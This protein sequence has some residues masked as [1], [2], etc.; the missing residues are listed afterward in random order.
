MMPFNQVVHQSK[1]NLTQ[2]LTEGSS[3]VSSASGYFDITFSR[4]T[5]PRWS[6]FR[7]LMRASPVA[8]TKRIML[9]RGT[10]MSRLY[11]W[12]M[13]TRWGEREREESMQDLGSVHLIKKMNRPHRARKGKQPVYEKARMSRLGVPHHWRRK[14]QTSWWFDF[15]STWPSLSLT[16]RIATADALSIPICVR[17][18]PNMWC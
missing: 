16:N 17:I 18:G 6:S 13:P 4:I 11:H 2:T 5:L 7:K 9:L 15:A 12:R 1:V 14:S 10:W 8:F 3:S